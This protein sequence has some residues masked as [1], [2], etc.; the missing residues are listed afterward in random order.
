MQDNFSFEARGEL[1][2][3]SVAARIDFYRAPPS[4]Q[5]RLARVH[6]AATLFRLLLTSSPGPGPGPHVGAGPG[7]GAGAG[8]GEHG[9]FPVS[10]PRHVARLGCTLYVIRCRCRCRCRCRAVIDWSPARY[11][12]L[13]N[14]DGKNSTSATFQL[15][16]PP[17]WKPP[18]RSLPT[19]VHRNRNRTPRKKTSTTHP[20]RP[21]RPT[22]KLLFITLHPISVVSFR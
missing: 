1:G 11:C 20:S 17:T 8:A 2:E 22:G 13:F 19:H 5:R 10:T 18:S 6:R 14:A 21:K 7:A 16:T 3:C 12:H 9:R 15:H 4:L